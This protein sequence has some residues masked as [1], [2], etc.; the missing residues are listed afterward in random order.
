MR[1]K[2]KGVITA[3]E[4]PPTVIGRTY[5]R[6]KACLPLMAYP[7]RNKVF[8]NRNKVFLNRNEVF[9]NRNEVFLNRNEVFLNRNEVFLIRNKV[10][11]AKNEVFLAR[12]KMRFWGKAANLAKNGA[13]LPFF[14]IFLSKCMKKY[15]VPPALRT[16]YAVHF[17]FQIL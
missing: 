15:T 2:R 6:L 14:W 7:A 5:G 16:G 4:R 13:F 12:N 8:L 11:L 9:L 1:E 17:P 10:F 3:V